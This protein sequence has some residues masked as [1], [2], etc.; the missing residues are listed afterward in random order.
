MTVR[1]YWF[2]IQSQSMRPSVRRQKQELLVVVVEKQL[3]VVK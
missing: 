3:L 1:P 2:L